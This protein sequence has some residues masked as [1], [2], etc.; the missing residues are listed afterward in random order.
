MRKYG[1]PEPVRQFRLDLPS[2]RNYFD[3]AYP[4]I[5]GA[6][7]ADSRLWHTSPAAVRRDRER[8]QAA[9][10]FGWTVERVTWLQLVETPADVVARVAALLA[11]KRAA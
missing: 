9:R 1:L 4:D 10:L 7:E 5:Q 6:I 3:F 8:D 2:G 11:V